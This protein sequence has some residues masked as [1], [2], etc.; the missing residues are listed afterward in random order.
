MLGL[1]FRRQHVIHGLIV[2]FFCVELNLV[3]EIDG[4]VHDSEEA[5]DS[6]IAR[7]T[8]LQAH[9][10]HVLRVRNEDVSEKHLCDLLRIFISL[11]SPGGRGA[12]GEA[13]FT[14]S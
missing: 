3:L 5:V 9:G 6:D 14:V 4:S 10:F 2:D 8:Y 11:P 7:S 13:G 1:K 12:G